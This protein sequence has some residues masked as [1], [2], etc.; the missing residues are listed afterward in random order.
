MANG[1][2]PIVLPRPKPRSDNLLTEIQ[3]ELRR[4]KNHEHAA[5]LLVTGL[6]LLR[7]RQGI[8]IP[9]KVGR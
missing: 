8:R 6:E 3:A 9:R 4:T 5:D 7:K 2:V 1:I